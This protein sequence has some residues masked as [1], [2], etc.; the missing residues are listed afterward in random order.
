MSVRVQ[1]KNS[2]SRKIGRTFV[3]RPRR[4]GCAKSPCSPSALRR[5]AEKGFEG[6]Y[7]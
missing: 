7:W 2:D 1:L 6:T 4:A 5:D 3:S